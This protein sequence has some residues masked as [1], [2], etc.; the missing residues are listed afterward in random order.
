MVPSEKPGG[1]PSSKNTG[2]HYVVKSIT[3]RI[4]IE[5]TNGKLHRVGDQ[6]TATEAKWVC[7]CKVYDVT[8]TD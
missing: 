4:E 3:N 8:I 5:S 6:L 7:E 1:L 2:E